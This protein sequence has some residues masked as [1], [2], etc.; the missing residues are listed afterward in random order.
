MS[1]LSSNNI[2]FNPNYTA[3]DLLN[4]VKEH[5]YKIHVADHIAENMGHEAVW[6][7]PYHSQCNPIIEGKE[8]SC[9]KNKMF[10]LWDV[11]NIF[12]KATDTVTAD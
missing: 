8:I 4:I 7:P 6:L 11:E 10:K 1:W 9:R 12:H 5:K 2:N 3:A